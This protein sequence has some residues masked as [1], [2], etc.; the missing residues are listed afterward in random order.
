MQGKHSV[1]AFRVSRLCIAVHSHHRHVVVCMPPIGLEVGVF[2]RIYVCRNLEFF[3]I[4]PREPK[5]QIP[6]QFL[7][8]GDGDRYTFPKLTYFFRSQ[9]GCV[10]KFIDAL[11]YFCCCKWCAD[12]VSPCCGQMFW[13]SVEHYKQGSDTVIK[14]VKVF[15]NDRV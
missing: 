7:L 1:L 9:P 5:V 10:S 4:W 3:K 13:I 15:N 8:G 2:L 12:G 6:I 11:Q 14:I